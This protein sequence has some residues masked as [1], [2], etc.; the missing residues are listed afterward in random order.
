MTEQ[1]EIRLAHLTKTLCDIPS[2]TGNE[3]AIADAVEKWAK[4]GP[5][6]FLPGEIRRR[7]R[8]HPLQRIAPLRRLLLGLAL[9]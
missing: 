8:S 3:K 9:I 1:L 4:E 5:A 2:V 6:H 7:R